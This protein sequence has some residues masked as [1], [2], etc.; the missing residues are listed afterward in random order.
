MG[1][2][3]T[4]S[5]VVEET[6]NHIDHQQRRE[7]FDLKDK[8]T[9]LEITLKTEKTTNNEVMAT[10]TEKTKALEKLGE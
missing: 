6:V 9:L 8:I 4:E 2:E 1:K 7:I 10:L 5:V 3:K